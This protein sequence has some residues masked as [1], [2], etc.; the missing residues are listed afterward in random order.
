MSGGSGTAQIALVVLAACSGPVASTPGVPAKTASHTSTKLGV[1]LA[2][3]T[4]ARIEETA[5]HVF[6]GNG[7][8]KLNLFA[9][10]E[11][12]AASADAQKFDIERMPGFL[13]LTKEQRNGEDWRFDYELERGKAG[14]I[15]RI[16]AGRAL[17][18]GVSGVAPAVAAEVGAACGNVKKL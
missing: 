5:D 16:H 14:T 15:A 13:K 17:D 18:C 9:V 1:Q 8:F 6:V 7:T 11:Y 12:S 4:D 3:P 2:A 10:D